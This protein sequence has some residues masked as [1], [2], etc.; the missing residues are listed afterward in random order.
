MTPFNQILNFQ[1]YYNTNILFG[2]ES[3]LLRRNQK[4]LKISEKNVI[5]FKILRKNKK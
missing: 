3:L 5:F 1:K 2:Q 4:V